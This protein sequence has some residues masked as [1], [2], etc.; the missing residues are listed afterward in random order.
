MFNNIE[1]RE[2]SGQQH[3]MKLQRNRL[4]ATDCPKQFVDQNG[5]LFF[6]IDMKLQKPF[7]ND[8][9][10]RYRLERAAY[11]SSLLKDKR[12]LSLAPAWCPDIGHQGRSVAS[13]CQSQQKWCL[14]THTHTQISAEIKQVDVTHR[15]RTR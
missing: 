8:L 10:L 12:T 1:T 7:K 13:R 14:H 6:R 11:D 2:C 4:T 3:A 9:P 15:T 5:S